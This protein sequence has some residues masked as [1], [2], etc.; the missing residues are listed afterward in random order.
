MT[1]M[2]SL[3]VLVACGGGDRS[4]PNLL[5]VSLDT[6]RWDRTSLAGSRDTTP[7]LAA[8]A[9]AGT[10][11]PNAWSVGNE[12]IYSHA[13]LLTGRYPSE[14]A[15]PDYGSFSVPAELPTLATVLSAYGYSTGAFTG[16]G[17]V[18][19]DYGF[20]SGFQVFQTATGDSR[21][22]SLF[23]AVPAA[24]AWIRGEEDRPWFAFVHGYD[25]HSPYVQR[26]PFRHLWGSAADA[27]R[28]DEIAA[29]PLAV[30]QIRGRQ[31]FPDR[32]PQDFLH[33]AGPK[34]LGLDVYTLPARP[35]PGERVVTL[36]EGEVTH[37]VDH[38]DSGLSYGDVW[39]G[40]L[41][42][43]V[44]LEDTLVVVLSDHG[45][46]LLDHGFVNHRTGLWDSTLRVPLVVAGPGFMGGGVQL[47]Q[48]DLRS[49]FPTL[50]Q[51]AG[52]RAPAG[53]AV[54]PLQDRP[55]AAVVYAEGVM[56]SVSVR[57]ATHR[58]VLSEAHLA[59]GA[60]DL[61]T[62]SLT[63]VGVALYAEPDSRNL[64]AD[65]DP[66][67]LAQAEHLRQALVQVRQGLQPATTTGSPVSPALREA[68]RER[69][70]W[71]PGEAPPPAGEPAGAPPAP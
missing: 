57:D 56:D 61:A 28:M 45:E 16:G 2:I 40:L 53:L 38:Y 69:G 35:R 15:L 10:T 48:V 66:A 71:A 27:G 12:S 67:Q 5:L 59:A 70:Y 7:N 3:L 24:L 54:P 13:A 20:D 23:D 6:V 22:G 55:D 36:T 9:A 63:G 26:G 18:I 32:R 68:L 41:L 49:T 58:L 30:E 4:P 64:L 21:A 33:A 1:A 62:R 65:G 51:A 19:A 39:L 34:L 11:W 43:E 29:D 14:V 17:H 50:L 31:W 42:A 8:L 46:D 60:S 52:A 47:G 25:A 37:L 44:D